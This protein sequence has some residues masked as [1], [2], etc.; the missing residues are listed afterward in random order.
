MK[1]FKIALIPGDG[2]GPEVIREGVNV[3]NSI[4]D[5]DQTF[6]FRSGWSSLGVVNTIQSMA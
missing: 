2:I 3:L 5:L 6:V 4:A 1:T